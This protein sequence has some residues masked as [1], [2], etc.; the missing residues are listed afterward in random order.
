MRQK[1]G[2]QFCPTSTVRGAFR[3]AAFARIK[4]SSHDVEDFATVE[5]VEFVGR[6]G[7][8][9]CGPGFCLRVL[10]R[11][12]WYLFLF[13]RRHVTRAHHAPGE[14]GLRTIAGPVAHF[15]ARKM[16]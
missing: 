9:R 7:L 11:R 2:F 1:L 6:V 8:V 3:F 15:R 5:R 16:P 4:H 13:P 14:L 10:A 12:G